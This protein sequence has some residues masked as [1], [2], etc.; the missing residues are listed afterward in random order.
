MSFNF[1]TFQIVNLSINQKV[2]F[3]L[4][5]VLVE[6]TNKYNTTPSYGVAALLNQEEEKNSHGTT[7]TLIVFYRSFEILA[8]D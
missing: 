3:I 7:Y 6:Q 1:M 8:H 4:K 2:S 5:P